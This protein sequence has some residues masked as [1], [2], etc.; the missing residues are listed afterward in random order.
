M[1]KSDTTKAVTIPTTNTITPD[2]VKAISALMIFNNEAPSMTG[3][4]MKKENSA[5]V[6]R[7]K[8]SIVPPKMVEPLLDVP[9]IR[10]STWKHPIRK[11]SLGPI[12]FTELMRYSCC[13]F[14]IQMNRRP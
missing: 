12:L 7:V 6:E 4:A 10:A 8:P 2:K 5:A 9:G 11:A 13:L 14:S 1:A 3:I